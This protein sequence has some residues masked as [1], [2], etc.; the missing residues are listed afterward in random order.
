MG[1]LLKPGIG[2]ANKT[3]FHVKRFHVVLGSLA[4]IFSLLGCNFP[5]LLSGGGGTDPITTP[6]LDLTFLPT[7]IQAVT[8]A[9]AP[10]S[11]GFST[12]TQAPTLNPETPLPPIMYYTQSG[13]T[14]EN[15]C[16]RF[17]VLPEE[18]TSTSPVQP[19]IY[20]LPGQLLFIP[21][22]LTNTTPTTLLMPDSEVLYS[23]TSIGFDLEGFIRQA[24]GY[25]STYS[26][27]LAVGTRS[28]ATI[29]QRVAQENSISPR[30][31]LALLE[32]QSGWVYGQPTSIAREQYPMGM[33]DNTHKGLYK[34]LNWAVKQIFAGYYGWRAGTLKNILFTDGTSLPIAPQVNAG[35]VALQTFFSRMYNQR[36]WGGVLYA[37]EGFPDLYQRM[38]DSPWVRAQA[39]EPF[40]PEG[41]AQPQLDLPFFPGK[42]WSFT[43]GP[44]AA[45]VAGSPIAALDFAP[46][47]DI[48]G[49]VDTYEWVTASASGLVVRS[50]NGVVILD[51]DG[52]GYEQTGWVILYLHIAE[53]GR[54]PVGAIV[55]VGEIIGHPSCEGG[56]ATGTHV[57]IAR[58][59]N[60]EWIPVDSP[61][62]FVLS[63]WQAHTGSRDY[64]GTLTRDGLTVTASQYGSFETKITNDA[65]TP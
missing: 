46:A 58:K 23:P 41:L 52:D 22:R 33:V 51:L 1:L 42:T 7:P 54:V 65:Y 20:L 55:N 39:F 21:A 45:W 60:G 62:P 47:T 31:L 3:K 13:D 34:Q 16:G 37:P 48:S 32:F 5:I 10:I 30:L 59:Y 43:G 4:L 25:L 50:E 44:H 56:S 2:A 27:Y 14:L 6:A 57:H 8:T 9:P 63:G 36:D 29:I 26:E 11:A 17:N 49:C 24:G 61:L 18:I 40:F 35:T 12:A 38:F 64:L 28:G 15:I 19:G 53:K